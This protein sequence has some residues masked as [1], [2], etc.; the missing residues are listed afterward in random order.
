[1]ADKLE[2]DIIGACKLQFSGTAHMLPMEQ[3]EKF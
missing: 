1:M 2:K 3:V